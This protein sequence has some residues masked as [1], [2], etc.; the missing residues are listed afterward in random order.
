MLKIFLIILIKI[1]KIKL[2]KPIIGIYGNSYPQND[3]KYHNGSYIPGSYIYYLES[4]GAELVA[5][6]QWYSYNEIDILLNQ[7]NGVLFPGGDRDVIINEF[8]ERKA[9]YIFKKC[10]EL[11]IPLFGICQGFQLINIFVAQDQNVLIKGYK[12]FSVLHNSSI[13]NHYKNH[14]LFS[15]F[16]P[17]D[18]YNFIHKNSSV[19]FHSLGVPIHLFNNNQLLSKYLKITSISEDSNKKSFINTI[20]GIND[21]IKVYAIQSHPEKIVYMR[22][23]NYTAQHSNVALKIS[24][25]IGLFFIKEVR[26]N[27]NIFNESLRDNYDFFNTYENKTKYFHYDYNTNSYYFKKRIKNKEK[28]K[29]DL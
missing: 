10:V 11:N 7:I 28:H 13:I 8:W 5:I 17:N 2:K 25:L 23:N 20:E 16:E 14:K 18:I 21:N 24:H 3:N 12:D 4:F 19:Y 15:L 6:H 22:S 9:L 27:S 1:I 26:K 29:L